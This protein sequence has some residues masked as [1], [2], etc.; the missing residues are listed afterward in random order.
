M[1]ATVNRPPISDHDLSVVVQG[2]ATA[3]LSQVVDSVRRHLPRAELIVSTWQDGDVDGLDVDD[4]VLSEDPGSVPYLDERRRP[5]PRMMNTNRML[6]STK[7]G[8]ARATREFTVKLRNDTP[9]RSAALL[10]WCRDPGPAGPA[11]LR[12]FSQRILITHVA[13]RPADAMRGYLFHPSDVVHLGR[14]VD[15]V[16]LW[17]VE[18]IDEEENAT[19]FCTRARPEPDLVP[20][21]QSRYVNEQVLWLSALRRHG[22]EPGYEHIGHYSPELRVRSERS[23]VANFELV[24]PWQLGVYLPFDDIVAQ[25]PVWQYVWRGDWNR[26]RERIGA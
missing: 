8:L 17:D 18:P 15:L 6:V 2:P 26:M 24:E 19:W 1:S 12:L 25:F 21:M 7:A 5:G 4:L 20:S 3:S 10:D 9:L 16:D 22:I 14:R 23:L 11:E 13:V